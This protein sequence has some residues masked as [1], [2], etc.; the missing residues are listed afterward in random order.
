[1]NTRQNLLTLMIAAAMSFAGIAM[2]QE[3]PPTSDQ[4]T[5]ENQEM[6]Q[7]QQ[8]EPLGM[9]ALGVG[10]TMCAVERVMRGLG[11]EHHPPVGLE[12][13]ARGDQ[14]LLD[15]LFLDPA[16]ADVD[17]DLFDLACEAGAGGLEAPP[18]MFEP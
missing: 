14:H 9:Q 13:L 16:P 7:Q 5:Q 8:T 4:A 1:M 15:V 10:D 11:V 6:Q 17:L 3:T 18:W 2:A 12:P